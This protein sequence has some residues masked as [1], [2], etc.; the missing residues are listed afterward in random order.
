MSIPILYIFS[1]LPGSGKSTLAIQLAKYIGATYLRIDTIEQALKDLYGLNI[2]AEGYQIAY[3]LASDNLLQGL[4]VISDSCN[5]VAK[6]RVEWEQTATKSKAKYINI[7][8]VCSNS[9]E[10]K[11]RIES[12]IAP[13]KELMLPTWIEVTKREYQPWLSKVIT[14]D[15]AGQT[16][17]QSLKKL[18]KSLG[19]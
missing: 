3:R 6:S 2:Y 9:I 19:V 1:G 18:I 16:P 8:I 12:R 15:T 4:D 14:I 13:I 7:E 10:H 11:Y 5:C 17:D